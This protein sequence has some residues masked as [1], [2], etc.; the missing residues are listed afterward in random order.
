MIAVTSPSTPSGPGLRIVTLAVLLPFLGPALMAGAAQAPP[1]T[2]GAS[3]IR[4]EPGPLAHFDEYVHRAVE[5]WDV[6]GLAVAVVKD[7]ELVF[8]QGYGV[9]TLA[10]D[11]RADPQTLFAIGSTTKAMTAAALGMLVDEGKISWDDP[12]TDHLPWFELH[13][14]YVTREI[15]VRD[16]LTHRG[17]LG[18]ADFLWYERETTMEDVLHR[19]RYA[20][21]A[22]SLRSSFI[23][24][25]IMYAAAGAVV[26]AVSGVSWN[27]FVRTRLF[28]PLGMT[29]TV[30]TLAEAAEQPNVASPH[31]RI[32]GVVEVIENASVDPVAPAGSVWSSVEDMSRW[33]RFLLAGGTTPDGAVL[34]K[35]ETVD[36]LFRPQGMVPADQFYPT[37]RLTEPSWTTYGLGWFQHDYGARKVD[38]HT[39]SIDGMVAIAG[40]I[41]SEGLGIYV[42]SNLDHAEL[43]HA[44]MY[45][46]FDVFGDGE[47]R[48]WSTELKALYDG[49]AAEAEAARTKREGDRVPGTSPSHPLEAYA[50]TYRDRLFGEAR[51]T[52]RDGLL[53]LESGPGLTGPLKHWHYDTF[54]V[55]WDARWRGSALVRFEIDASGSVAAVSVASMRLA[56]VPDEASGG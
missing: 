33:L 14:P 29:R 27:E 48:D 23:Y 17:G 19:I 31:Y 35:A 54:R 32:D 49:L 3:V 6:P 11:G 56:R 38:F 25:N 9:R 34:L 47:P 43:R 20:E 41:R 46:V 36:E 24:Q 22:Y 45:R 37:A 2:A 4:P 8:S 18:N 53:H 30:T 39:G 44:L 12:V 7:G 16:L 55:R 42:L 10:G 51:V 40:L 26:A 15:T 52:V 28:E 21:P 50:G 1:E 13:D 5:D